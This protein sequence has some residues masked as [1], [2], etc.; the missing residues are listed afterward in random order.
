M[1]IISILGSQTL[2]VIWTITKKILCSVVVVEWHIHM[3]TNRYSTHL[4]S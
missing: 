2:I 1:H 3:L 4:E